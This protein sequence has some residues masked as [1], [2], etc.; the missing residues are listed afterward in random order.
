MTLF[1][2]QKEQGLPLLRELAVDFDTGQPIIGPDG[3]F[4]RVA[5]LEAVRVW[6]W[7]ALLGDNT[8][9]RWSAHTQS[10]GNQFSLLAGRTLAEAES[11]LIAMVR[12]ALLVCPYITGVERFFFSREEARLKAAFTVRTVYGSMTAE[13]EAEL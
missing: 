5:G 9:F 10:Y 2:Y 1:S 12:E 13:S 8:R 3:R 6:V 11:R 7:R 4:R